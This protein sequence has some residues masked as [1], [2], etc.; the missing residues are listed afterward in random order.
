[1]RSLLLASGL[2]FAPLFFDLLSALDECIAL[3]HVMDFLA[4]CLGNGLVELHRSFAV[5]FDEPGSIAQVL[6]PLDDSK[7]V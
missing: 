3:R 7:S 5:C 6:T 1:M 4:A 2:L